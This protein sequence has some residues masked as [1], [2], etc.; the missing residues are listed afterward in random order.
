MDEKRL[1][2]LAG[3]LEKRE[4]PRGLLGW[5]ADL[6]MARKAGNVKLARELKANID[7]QIKKLNLNSKEV[8]FAFGDPD[9]PNKKASVLKAI[10][11]FR[12]QK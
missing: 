9:D 11:V 3:L 6:I 10:S 7:K 2:K 12:K 5:V 8:F 4:I 1:R